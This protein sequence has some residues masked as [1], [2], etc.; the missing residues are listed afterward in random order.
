[1]IPGSSNILAIEWDRTELRYVWAGYSARRVIIRAI[2]RIAADE[3]PDATGL[4]EHLLADLK[5]TLRARKSQVISCLSRSDVDEFEAT[6][7]PAANDELAFLVANEAHKHYPATAEDAQIDF[8]TIE[9]N[10]DQTRRVSVIVLPRHR[11]TQIVESTQRLGWKLASIQLRHV[12][13]TRLLGKL[14]DLSEHQ[15][16]ILLS[17]SRS[18]ADLVILERGQIVMVRT[19]HLSSEF[20][21]GSL[22]DKLSVEIQ[23][24]L[25]ITTKPD[26]VDEAGQ[27]QLFLFGSSPEQQTLQQQMA[28]VLGMPVILVDP[29][30]PFASHP[31]TL[32]VQVH[33]FA[34]LLGSLLEPQRSQSID[35]HTPKCARKTSPWRHRA[36]IYSSAVVLSLVLMFVWANQVV[37]Q[38]S[39]N[40]AS[41]KLALDNVQKQL[42]SMQTKMEVVDYYDKWITD[43]VNWLDELRELSQKFPERS[44]M[45]VKTMILSTG[46]TSD[47]VISMSVRA[48]DNSAIASLEQ[49]VRDK[50]HQI[51]TNQLSQSESDKEFPWQFEASVMLRRRD[52]EEF[53]DPTG[54]E[55][56]APSPVEPAPVPQALP[57]KGDPQ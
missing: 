40:N 44:S 8:L 50:N 52:R 6:L 47:G 11:Y 49:R 45:Q 27:A 19:I 24:S 5:E 22:A 31:R 55:T 16:S 30:Q 14:H 21:S 10:P 20:D 51:R 34:G 4:P 53:I 13:A 38:A 28:T 3:S 26:H 2:G 48:K 18:D 29:L 43:D 56:S 35:L 46:T 41:L 39:N 17:I 32:P 12:A 15:R 7:P 25:M 23:R 1:M 33:Q 42:E 9:Q 57:G 54:K 36:I 37:S